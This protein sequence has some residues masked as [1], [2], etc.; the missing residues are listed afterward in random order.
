MGSRTFDRR[1]FLA[2]TARAGVAVCGA[3]ICGGLPVYAEGEEN[4]PIDPKKLNYC[5][6]TCP[7]EC[8]FKKGTLTNDVKLKKEAWRLWKIE[9]RFGLEFDPDQAI[10]YGCK[11]LDKP[12]GVVLARCTVRSCAQEKKLDCCIECDDLVDCE[13]D[14]WSRFPDFKMQVIGMQERYRKQA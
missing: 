8:K 5:G 10:C 4:Q 13:K 3:C 7:D 14:L 9:E 1:A 12:E 6:Y 2:N 11:E